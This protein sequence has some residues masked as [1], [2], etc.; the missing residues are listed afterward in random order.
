MGNKQERT[1]IHVEYLNEHYYFGSMSAIYTV[2][3]SED[4]GVAL[5][6]LRNY[7]LSD[8]KP[9]VSAKCTIRK[10]ILRTI[11]KKQ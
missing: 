8:S 7:R 10:G 2:F 6:T 5:G 4:L 9:Y 3:T 11:P 1:V